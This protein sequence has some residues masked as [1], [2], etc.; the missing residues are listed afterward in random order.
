MI[1]REEY[2][3]RLTSYCPFGKIYSEG[4]VTPYG[5]LRPGCHTLE[6][7]KRFNQIR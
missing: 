3:R 4:I 5:T 2:D 6:E 7:L 1:P